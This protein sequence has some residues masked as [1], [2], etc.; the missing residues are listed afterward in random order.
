MEIDG[1]PTQDMID[2][3]VRRGAIRAAGGSHGPETDAIRFITDAVGDV[4]GSWMFLPR[5][6]FL[7]GMDEIPY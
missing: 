7:T 5:E 4:N 2:E 3:L 6:T 1:H